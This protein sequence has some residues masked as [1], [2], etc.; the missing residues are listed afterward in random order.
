MPA[1]PSNN[2]ICYHGT[3]R[4]PQ[5]SVIT[6]THNRDEHLRNVLRGIER[7]SVR[8]AEVVIVYMNQTEQIEDTFSVPSTVVHLDEP[9]KLPLAKARNIGAAQATSEYLIFLDVDCIPSET[10]FEDLLVAPKFANALIMGSPRYLLPDS[11]IAG[12]PEKKLYDASVAHKG[13]AHLKSGQSQEYTAFWSLCFAL[14]KTTFEKIG[15]FD[16]KFI[17]YGG[18]DTDFALAAK[19]ADVPFVISDAICYHQHHAVYK[20]PV[21]HAKDIVLNSNY[22]FSKWHVWPMEGW[23]KEFVRLGIIEWTPKRTKPI[24]VLT[25]DQVQAEDYI[26][27]TSAY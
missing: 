24:T 22:Y 11:K 13:R 27:T 7:S 16:T 4:T 15:G 21:Q 23:L 10:M 8:P 26:D 9:T 20:P 6:I 14:T 17:G 1:E 18:E 19:V 2:L 3:M 5:F 12:M 25:T